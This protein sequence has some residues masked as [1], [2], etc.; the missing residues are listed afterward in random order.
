MRLAPAP[1]EV[2]VEEDRVVDDA[3]I[4]RRSKITLQS[5][6]DPMISTDGHVQRK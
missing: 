4:K 1:R 2:E 5:S 6:P 3:P